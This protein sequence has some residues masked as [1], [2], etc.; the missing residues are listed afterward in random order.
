MRATHVLSPAVVVGIDGSRNALTAALWA[1]DE[2]VERD[3]P[4]RL[5]YAID[6]RDTVMNPRDEAHTSPT[7]RSP[8]GESS[9]PSNRL[10]RRRPPIHCALH[11]RV[12]SVLVCN[13]H[14]PL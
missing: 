3:I 13:A 6:P 8:S 5:V 14:H 7:R 9:P 2:A 11:D 1:V 10:L 4:L 12:C